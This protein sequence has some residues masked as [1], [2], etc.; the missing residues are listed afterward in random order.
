[1]EAIDKISPDKFH[2]LSGVIYR[3]DP[4]YKRLKCIFRMFESN[5]IHILQKK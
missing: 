2:N 5:F 1:M 4:S 3:N